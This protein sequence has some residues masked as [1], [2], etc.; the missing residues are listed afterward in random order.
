MDRRGVE[1]AEAE[2]GTEGAETEAVEAVEVGEEGEGEGEEGQ[3][4]VE[5][6]VIHSCEATYEGQEKVG[7]HLEVEISR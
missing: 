3:R 2:G 1:T 5:E 7:W 6:L 4:L